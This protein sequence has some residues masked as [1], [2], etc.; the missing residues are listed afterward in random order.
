M[1]Y[2][3]CFWIVPLLVVGCGRSTPTGPVVL[4]HLQHASNEDE[5][6]GVALAV[7]EMNADPA[8]HV[9]G[10][11]LR[12][13]HADAGANPDEAQGQAARLVTLDKVDALI[14]GSRWGSVERLTLA[15][16]SPSTVAVTCNGYGGAAAAPNLFP[17]GAAPAEIGRT[18]A[19]HC[20]EVLKVAK[21][22]VLREADAVV[23]GVIA[24]SFAEHFGSASEQVIRA[25]ES[26]DSLKDLKADAILLCASARAALGWRGK[27]PSGIPILFGGEEADLPILQRESEAKRD[28]IGVSSF[29]GD[30]SSQGIRDFVQRYQQRFGKPPTAAAA[31]S[32]EAVMIWSEAARRANEAT[33]D[34]VRE[35]LARKQATFAVLSGSLW[36]EAEQS[37]RRPLFA[38][39][40]SADGIKLERRYDP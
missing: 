40:V 31:L 5:V 2:R 38:V 18:L 36:F 29:H 28:I 16:Q 14:G 35:Q 4:G 10:R 32:Y 30:D 6:H 17:I 27:L 19:R 21:V 12:A 34:K 20:K 15:A 7:E 13:I 9:A 37:P 24:K 23:P 22:I 3:H 33:S 39:R 1:P 11:K 26:P 25:N 8:R